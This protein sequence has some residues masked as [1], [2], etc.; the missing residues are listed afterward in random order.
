ME[1]KDINELLGVTEEDLERECSQ[2]ESG[3]WEGGLR[4]VTLGRPRLYDEDMSTV[5]FRLPASQQRAVAAAS[6]R[7]GISKSEFFRNAIDHELVACS[8]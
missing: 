6:E 2:Y 5:S 8:V 3:T 4:N 1:R 7:L